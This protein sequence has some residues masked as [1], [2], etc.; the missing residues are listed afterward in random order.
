MYLSFECKF[1]K[2]HLSITRNVFYFI[3]FP[4][5]SAIFVTNAWEE[6]NKRFC[7][8]NPRKNRSRIIATFGAEQ[9][10]QSYK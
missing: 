1:I 6:A 9:Q 7:S 4:F 2:N 10:Q 8:F 3:H 5:D